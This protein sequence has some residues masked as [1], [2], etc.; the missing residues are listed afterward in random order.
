MKKL[1]LDLSAIPT[2]AQQLR[3]ARKR[4]KTTKTYENAVDVQRAERELADWRRVNIKE[5]K[6]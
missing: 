4:L 2:P 1:P 5:V 3:E 6:E